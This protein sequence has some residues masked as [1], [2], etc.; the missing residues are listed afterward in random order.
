MTKVWT[1]PTA[2]AAAGCGE[3]EKRH[4][5]AKKTVPVFA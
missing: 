5:G 4:L 1:M 3:T 2:A